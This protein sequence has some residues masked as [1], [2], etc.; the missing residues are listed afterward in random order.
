KNKNSLKKGAIGSLLMVI[1]VNLYIGMTLPNI[2]NYGHIGGL[3][4]GIIIGGVF[5]G[6]SFKN[7]IE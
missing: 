7:Q 5:L 2:D 6:Q 3:I 1:G 4:V